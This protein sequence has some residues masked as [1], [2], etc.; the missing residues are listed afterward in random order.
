MTIFEYLNCAPNQSLRFSDQRYYAYSS[1]LLNCYTGEMLTLNNE[2]TIAQQLNITE[3]PFCIRDN[4]GRNIYYEN[5]NGYWW[6]YEYD[7]RGNMIYS[8]TPDGIWD[9]WEY[10]TNGKQTR[11][12]TSEGYWEKREYNADG[13]GIYFEDSKGYWMK[14]AHNQD[15]TIDS[16]DSNGKKLVL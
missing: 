14:W 13:R 12:E 11:H 16:E 6:K 1:V 10:D 7:T 3:F 9:K 2:E 4:K 15:G 8:E 5:K